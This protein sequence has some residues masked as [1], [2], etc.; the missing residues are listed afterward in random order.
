MGQPLPPLLP[1]M[2]KVKFYDRDVRCPPPSGVVA[3]GVPP[4]NGTAF[5][6]VD[7]AIG[8]EGFTKISR[9]LGLKTTPLCL[10]TAMTTVPLT[11]SQAK[12][13]GYD[14]SE[15]SEEENSQTLLSTDQPEANM[16]LEE[17]P[18]VLLAAI[19]ASEHQRTLAFLKERGKIDKIGRHASTLLESTRLL[20][21][22]MTTNMAA[23]TARMDGMDENLAAIRRLLENSIVSSSKLAD[24]VQALLAQAVTHNKARFRQGQ[25]AFHRV[26]DVENLVA[27]FKSALATVTRALENLVPTTLQSVLEQTIPPTLQTILD[28]TISPTLQNVLNGTFSEFTS[29][30]ESVGDKMVHEVKTTLEKQWESLTTDYSSVQASLQEVL[31]RLRTLECTYDSSTQDRPGSEGARDLNWSHPTC[32]DHEWVQVPNV[33]SPHVQFGPEGTSPLAANIDH[34]P[35]SEGEPGPQESSTPSP[36]PPMTWGR[37][38]QEDQDRKAARHHHRYEDSELHVDTSD[39]KAQGSKIVSPRSADRA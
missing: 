10:A 31:A 2:M 21:E 24:N 18:E 15:F 26:Q 14:F 39:W 38:W 28:D 33:S 1:W 30:Y 27:D 23:F 19:S 34:S 7:A 17:D 36:C 20:T 4:I 35:T 5:T 32:S 11:T 22:S 37:Q 29:R 13:G 25:V 8:D 9:A 12:V 3:A 16:T 6:T